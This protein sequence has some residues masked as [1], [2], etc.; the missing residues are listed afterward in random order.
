MKLTS[1]AYWVVVLMGIMANIFIYSYFSRNLGEYV[2]NDTLQKMN[3]V[4]SLDI[5]EQ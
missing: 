4:P 3:S 1:K 5:N 2:Y